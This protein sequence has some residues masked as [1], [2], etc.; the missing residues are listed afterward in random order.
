MIG[1]DGVPLDTYIRKVGITRATKERYESLTSEEQT[2]LQNYANGVN[3]VVD[4]IKVYPAEFQ[5]L[6]TS[7]EPWT[8]YDSL[9]CSYFL[10]F[11]G[12]TDW[13]VEML[14]VR[15]LEVYDRDL[16]D[17]MIPFKPEH[18]YPFENVETITDADLAKI[19]MLEEDSE[20][21][22]S[23]LY[24]IDESLIYVP[25]RAD[26][27]KLDSSSRQNTKGT[28][29]RHTKIQSAVGSNCFSVHGNYTQK[30]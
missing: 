3:K 30:G 8:V 5:F 6:M 18:I 13:F 12:S 28:N 1:A 26:K 27:V 22:Y 7:F 25:P 19:G 9:S 14:R 16:V 10:T 11:M 29:K 4:N 24:D 15:L 20:L 17:Q 23:S 21:S 2:V